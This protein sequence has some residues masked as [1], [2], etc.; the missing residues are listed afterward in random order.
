MRLYEYEAK[1]VFEQMNIPIPPQFGLINSVD[2]LDAVQLEFPLVIKSMVLVGGRGKAGGIKKAASIHEA[3]NIAEEMLQLRIKDYDVKFLLLEKAVE[4]KD[5][6]YLGITTDPVTFDVILIASAS[7]GVDIEEVARTSP[8][9][10]W[11]RSLSDN[12]MALSDEI[13]SEAAQ[14]LSETL[15]TAKGMEDQFADVISKL[16]ETFQHHDAKVCE[17]NPLAITEEGV[18]A[19]DA[20]FV[21][22][23]NALY[24]QKSLLESLGIEGKRHDVA[25]QTSFEARAYHTGFPYVDLV[26]EPEGFEKDPAKLYV[27]LV[28]GGAGYGILSIDEVVNVGNRYF[29]GRVVPINFMDS[30]GGPPVSTVAEMFDLLMD[31]PIPDVIITSR[32]GGISSCDV[33]IRGLIKTLRNRHTDGKRILPI[34]GRMVGTDLPSAAAYLEKAKNETPEPL[35]DLHIVVGNQKIMVD[36]IKDGISYAFERR[37]E[38]L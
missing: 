19:L 36:V 17:V 16:Y 12:S 38:K 23:D 30:G 9:A 7:G 22:D 27:A 18:L 20:K 13:A 1:K 32:F 10:I 8:D 21:I 24:R 2:E 28:P 31:H 25:E 6:I 3:K 4:I 37:G 34:W 26:M 11:K 35:R 29:N 33:F 15:D 5:E 14:F